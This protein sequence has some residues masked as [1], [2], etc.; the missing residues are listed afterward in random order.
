[1]L[2]LRLFANGVFSLSIGLNFVIQLSLFGT[3]LSLPLFLQT[4]QGL[5]P[6]EAGLIL[7]PQGVASFL[8]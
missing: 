2:D 6:L 1:M 3:Q 4:A 5:G 8:R 7:M